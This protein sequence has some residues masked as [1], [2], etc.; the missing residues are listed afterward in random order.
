MLDV[1]EAEEAAAL[2]ALTARTL[3][4][5]RFAAEALVVAPNDILLVDEVPL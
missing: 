2:R 3:L 4:A 1:T 5:A